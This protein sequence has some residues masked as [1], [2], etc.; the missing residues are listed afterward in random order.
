MRR[1]GYGG[2][3][4]RRTGREALKY[5]II[6]LIVLIGVLAAILFF[7]EE[8]PEQEQQ[9]EQSQQVQEPE[10]NPEPEPESEPEPEPEPEVEPFV[11]QAMEVT[12]S[13]VAENNWRQ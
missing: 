4:G 6:G 8:E 9:P 13:Q 7:G 2:Y 1:N 10:V 5:V 11:M 3:R 12:M